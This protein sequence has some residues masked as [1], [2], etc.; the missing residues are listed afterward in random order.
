MI[1]EIEDYGAVEIIDNCEEGVSIGIIKGNISIGDI[2][3]DDIF[4]TDE[5]KVRIQL[6]E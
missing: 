2:D 4:N 5:N 3:S 6:E 1:I